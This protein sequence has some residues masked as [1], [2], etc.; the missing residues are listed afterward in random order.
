MR[1]CGFCEIEAPVRLPLASSGFRRQQPGPSHLLAHAEKRLTVFDKRIADICPS[2]HLWGTS[3][4]SLAEGCCVCSACPQ[5][6]GFIARSVGR[7]VCACVYLFAISS[8]GGFGAVMPCIL[9]VAT[10]YQV[11]QYQY[12]LS[13]FSKSA[14]LKQTTPCTAFVDACP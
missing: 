7:G 12:R 13:L 14:F 10:V 6:C 2:V 4:A 11:L 1:I 3:P 9:A 8:V 5:Y